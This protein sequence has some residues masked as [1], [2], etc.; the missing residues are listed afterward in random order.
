MESF[1]WK[2]DSPPHC[3]RNRFDSPERSTWEPNRLGFCSLPFPLSRRKTCILVGGWKALGSCWRH[4][5]QI[6]SN[7]T[8]LPL[9]LIKSEFQ[10][11]WQHF[12][13]SSS[14]HT[15][16]GCC[17]FLPLFS[18][19]VGR[20]FIANCKAL[21]VA[22]CYRHL[23]YYFIIINSEYFIKPLSERGHPGLL[24]LLTPWND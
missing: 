16:Q 9:C 14:S 12:T 4:L 20:Q 17:A 24:E 10:R 13:S 6:G 22:R 2:T 15:S 1:P 3:S 8:S 11:A 5:V 23:R 19:A 18:L 21:R 7:P